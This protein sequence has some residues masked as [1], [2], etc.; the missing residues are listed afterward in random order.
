MP[1]HKAERNENNDLKGKIMMLGVENLDCGDKDN[2]T[3][4]IEPGITQAN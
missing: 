3:E 1:E 2:P 4:K